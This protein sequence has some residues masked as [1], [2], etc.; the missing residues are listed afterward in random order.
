[1]RF[2]GVGGGDGWMSNYKE[3]K[4]QV[5]DLIIIK[6]H[7]YHY[8][9]HHHHHHTWQFACT[10]CQASVSFAWA[11]LKFNSTSHDVC[12]GWMDR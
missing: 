1:V 7:Y 3:S 12:D 10:Q 9:H 2:G 6:W 5:D 4:H 11:L 8:H